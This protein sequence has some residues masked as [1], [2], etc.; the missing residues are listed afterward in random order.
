MRKTELTESALC[1]AVA[2]MAQGLIDADLGG[3]VVK[4]ALGLQAVA[5]GVAPEHWWLPTRATAGSSSSGLKRMTGPTLVLMSWRLC[6][7]SLMTYW[8]AL[9]RSLI[10]R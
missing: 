9:G 3:G 6:R 8:P 1:S 2:E 7:T 10:L 4:N 5:N